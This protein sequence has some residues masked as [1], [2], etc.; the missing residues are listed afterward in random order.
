M[1]DTSNQE[2]TPPSDQLQVNGRMQSVVGLLAI[3]NLFSEGKKP[4]TP[5]VGREMLVLLRSFNP[6]PAAEEEIWQA[7]LV[8][9]YGRYLSAQRN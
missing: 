3:F 9:A 8:E 1:T 4:C 5:G 7:A 2:F 6:I